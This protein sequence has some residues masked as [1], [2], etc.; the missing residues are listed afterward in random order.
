MPESEKPQE[1]PAGEKPSA[2]KP[3]LRSRLSDEER[4]RLWRRAVLAK[5]RKLK[6]MTDV[7][8][9]VLLV[10][11]L[12]AHLLSFVG[13]VEGRGGWEARSGFQVVGMLLG[14]KHPYRQFH[15]D[16]TGRPKVSRQTGQRLVSLDAEHPAGFGTILY[17]V[18]PVGAAILVLLY[19]LDYFAWMGRAL[20]AIS[21]IYGIGGVVYL[22]AAKLPLT[23]TWNALGY[24]A[25][26]AWYLLLIPLFLVGAV[27]M[28]R[29][30]VSH[31]WKR[32]E[33]AGL[34]VPEHLRPAPPAEEKVKGEKGQEKKADAKEPGPA[35][36]KGLEDEPKAPEQKEER[37]AD[38]GGSSQEGP[39]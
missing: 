27:S 23:G 29:L 33:F 11:I 12:L 39:K 2:E 13:E 14:G 36:G 15:L 24:R 5:A 20:P 6:L 26:A 7:L 28:L 35:A 32:Y 3:K 21:G 38:Q 22:V 37:A 16:D 17:L 18:V 8:L 34:P 31:R 19:L 10:V 1:K 4:K 30:V 9:F 25:L